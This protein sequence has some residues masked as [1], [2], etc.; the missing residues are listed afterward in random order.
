MNC[1]D[2]GARY[3]ETHT[4]KGEWCAIQEDPNEESKGNESTTEKNAK[5]GTGLEDREGYSNGEWKDE[6]TSD[7]IER[8]IDVFQSVIAET[9]DKV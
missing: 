6:T 1:G 9:V 4:N 7:L 3:S 8:C 5:R 2:G